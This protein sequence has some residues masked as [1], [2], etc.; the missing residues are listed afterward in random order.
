MPQFGNRL[1]HW[2]PSADLRS[3]TQRLATA[4]IAERLSNRLRKE[5]VREM[6]KFVYGAADVPGSQAMAGNLFE[7]IAF[8]ALAKGG[9]FL[10][11]NLK[12]GETEEHTFSFVNHSQSKRSKIG[13][14]SSPSHATG[15][16][17]S[18][19]PS[20]A[21]FAGAP[22]A[23]TLLQPTST[24]FGMPSPS[25]ASW[26]SNASAAVGSS[27]TS[28]TPATSPRSSSPFTSLL[29]HPAPASGEFEVSIAAIE[30]EQLSGR[31]RKA[32]D[33]PIPLQNSEG[34]DISH[35]FHALSEVE[36]IPADFFAR[37]AW[38]SLAGIDALAKPRSL[39]QITV[40]AEHSVNWNGLEAALAVMGAKS[41][42]LYFVVPKSVFEKFPAQAF[43]FDSKCRGWCKK[44]SKDRTKQCKECGIFCPFITQWAIRVDIDAVPDTFSE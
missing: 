29:A 34:R 31:K 13:A 16:L 22:S 25:S 36:G 42:D 14:S 26:P 37:P 6:R 43:T 33:S 19:S 24:Q 39:F 2:C 3:K 5:C 27:S 15:A 30:D 4:Y 21:S 17:A 35:V 44:A 23:N 40:S 1:I 38:S 8:S 28:L 20:S 7:P 12:S 41:A 32:P 10:R 11:R 18:S 9:K